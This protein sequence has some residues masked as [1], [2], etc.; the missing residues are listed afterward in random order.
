MFRQENGRLIYTYDGETM[1]IEPWGEN[2][3]R[4]RA[5]KNRAM[6]DTDWALLPQ[7]EQETEI[8]IESR[9]AELK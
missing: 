8:R 2:S 5:T 1:W 3:L 9:E 7:P 6:E 4:I